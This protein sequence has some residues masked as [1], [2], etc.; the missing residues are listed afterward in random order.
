LIYPADCEG[1]DDNCVAAGWV[2]VHW[3]LAVESW[4]EQEFGSPEGLI[5]APARISLGSVLYCPRCLTQ[6]VSFR[7]HCADCP[8]VSL[9][10]F[11]D[12][13]PAARPA[14]LPRK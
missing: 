14:P 7:S 10:P 8:R 4:I 11:G 12:P 1:C 13:L 6:Y 2:A 5:Q 9:R 3:R